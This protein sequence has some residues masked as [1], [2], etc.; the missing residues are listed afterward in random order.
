MREI[1]RYARGSSDKTE[2]SFH[3]ILNV[4]ESNYFAHNANLPYRKYNIIKYICGPL[5]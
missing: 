5:F 2:F 1:N 3:F 4:T